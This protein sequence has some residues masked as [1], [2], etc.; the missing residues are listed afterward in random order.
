MSATGSD[1]DATKR[2][3]MACVIL[4]NENKQAFEAVLSNNIS[5]MEKIFKTG[6]IGQEAIGTLIFVLKNI[7]MLML[8]L[9]H[10]GDMRK[11][12]PHLHPDPVS[13]LIEYTARLGNCEAGSIERKELVK[14]IKFLIKEG[15]DINAKDKNGLTA[16]MIC[17]GGGEFELLKLLIEKGADPKAIQ[18]YGATALHDAASSGSAPV[19][20][21]LVEECGL[22]IEVLSSDK[23]GSVM[24]QF[25]SLS[26][27]S[28]HP[29]NCTRSDP[30]CG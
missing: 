28:I 24:R 16:F 11:I 3:E 2:Y 27:P 1:Q 25:E 5:K 9:R 20:R 26:N 15:V 19:C 8:F 23:R 13:L 30:L 6:E 29:Q 10:G 14:M 12:G 22:D 18:K 21:Y 4:G 17:A 7:D